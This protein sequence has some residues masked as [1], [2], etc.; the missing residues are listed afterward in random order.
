MQKN[1]GSLPRGQAEWVS[2]HAHELADGLPRPCYRWRWSCVDLPQGHLQRLRDY[3]LIEQTDSGR[4]R[5][6]ERCRR[7]VA[8]Y[9]AVPVDEVGVDRGQV[10]LAEVTG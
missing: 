2:A 6:T 8:D 4:W 1:V 9:G 5:T 7:A 3:G 10:V